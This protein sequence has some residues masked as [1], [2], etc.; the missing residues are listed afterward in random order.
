MPTVVASFVVA[1]TKFKME[2]RTSNAVDNI[3]VYGLQV[4]ASSGLTK[5]LFTNLQSPP[6][7]LQIFNEQLACL[8]RLV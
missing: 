5:D 6:P 2:N 4:G 8:L 3:S 1:A 7:S